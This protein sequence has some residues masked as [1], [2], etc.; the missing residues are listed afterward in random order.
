[1][2]LTGRYTICIQGDTTPAVFGGGGRSA[3][4]R[5]YLLDRLLSGEEVDVGELESWGLHVT[6]DDS[7]EIERL[8]LGPVGEE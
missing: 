3:T 5:H 8:T 2:K 1:M 7:V 4:S 6:L